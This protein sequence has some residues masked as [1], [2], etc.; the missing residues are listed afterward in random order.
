MAFDPLSW[1][2]SFSLGGAVK[3]A[4]KKLRPDEFTRALRAAV[5]AW[6]AELPPEWVHIE[7][8]FAIANS[9]EEATGDRAKLAK[10]LH[11]ERIPSVQVWLAALLEQWREARAA[12]D[13]SPWPFFQLSEADV[14]PHL[15]RLAVELHAAGGV[16]LKRLG[17]ELLRRTQ[18]QD[19]AESQQ[20]AQHL[21]DAHIAPPSPDDSSVDEINAA[22]QQLRAGHLTEARDA[23]EELRRSRWASLGPV[24]KYRVLANLGI[25]A[26]R[27]GDERQAARLFFE[28]FDFNPN[29]EKA[30]LFQAWAIQL[31]GDR[32]RSHELASALRQEFPSMPGAAALWVR[33][34]PPDTE[35]AFI[36]S[37]LPEHLHEDA[38]VACAIAQHA[39]ALEDWESAEHVLRSAASAGED[40]PDLLQLL[41]EVLLSQCSEQVSEAGIEAAEADALRESISLFGTAE[42][43]LSPDENPRRLASL[44]LN[45]AMAHIALGDDEAARRQIDEVWS[46]NLT[47][48]DLRLRRVQLS[49]GIVPAQRL[50]TELDSV[51]NAE[52]VPPHFPLVYALALRRRKRDG[53]ADQA[54]DRLRELF[55]PAIQ[56]HLR[57]DAAA[58]A[59]QLLIDAERLSDAEGFLLELDVTLFPF[60]PPLLRA[61]LA[62]KRN[63]I[64]EARRLADDSVAALDDAVTPSWRVRLAQLLLDVDAPEPA[65]DIL[66]QRVTNS[67]LSSAEA[68]LI[69]AAE[70]AGHHQFL[71]AYCRQLR[72]AGVASAWLLDREITAL[73][74]AGDF[75]RAIDAAS[76][77][78]ADHPDDKLVR[79]QRSRLALRIGR[80]DFVDSEPKHLVDVDDATPTVGVATV[81]VLRAKAEH[82]RARAFAYEL[83]RRHRTA[84]EAHQAFLMAMAAPFGPEATD[85]M[86]ISRVQAGTAVCLQ[87]DDEETW[88]IIEDGPDASID[89]DE[90]AP[91]HPLAVSLLDKETGDV[92]DIGR[93]RVRQRQATIKK[94]LSKHVFRYHDVLNNW[95]RRFPD[96]PLVEMFRA[97]SDTDELQALLS[98]SLESSQRRIER[99]ERLY[100][101]NVNVSL[102]MFCEGLTTTIVGGIGHLASRPLCPIK[103]AYVAG[104]EFALFEAAASNA[105]KVIAAPSALA[106]ALIAGFKPWALGFDLLL[107]PSSLDQLRRHVVEIREHAKA[108]GHLTTEG[109]RVVLIE[110]DR[111]A[112][113]ASADRLRSFIADLEVETTS[114]DEVDCTCFDERDW[115]VLVQAIGIG[116]AE[117]VAH[118]VAA[119]ATL[120]T[121]D[122][123]SGGFAFKKGANRIWSQLALE[124]GHARGLVTTGTNADVA[125]QLLGMGYQPTRPT[126]LSFLAAS[127]RARW[128]PDSWPLAQHLDLFASRGDTNEVARY[129]AVVLKNIWR[130]APD[131]SPAQAITIRILERLAT[132]QGS[133]RIITDL[134]DLIDTTFGLDVLN[135][136]RAKASIRGWLAARRLYE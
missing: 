108:D 88:L 8:M 56:R 92:V 61:E 26:I 136:D 128:A 24:E 118:A 34:I 19:E 6:H 48:T 15:R 49:L 14:R 16:D 69:A 93:G 50:V 94:I 31:R 125:A 110:R 78:L 40:S 18:I 57:E 104:H 80:T 37:S 129:A 127:R 43:Q 116:E 9:S 7:T 123:V 17:P 68:T 135:A 90:Y 82:Q 25:V 71:K 105:T 107:T 52:D 74:A 76:S 134:L 75:S 100:A 10:E 67:R 59:A 85:D 28:A 12:Q 66:K 1:A 33:T 3:H 64:E 63:D 124:E 36:L 121:D 130:H 72:D 103:C 46:L 83:Y 79:L 111:A 60:L 4:W 106:T 20:P 53:D 84:P 42:Q 117:C 120:W 113:E 39:V 115:Q 95:E 32:P 11:A 99:L 29:D 70:A 54:V 122:A 44:R 51:A 5:A 81:E 126:A 23:L 101:E 96:K 55:D 35:P 91:K 131:T 87:E 86:S 65:F 109:G 62:L 13:D 27:L 58:I 41:G 102:H 89:H 47:D 22:V 97:P 73:A 114:V 2:L 112:L 119:K 45:L 38:D 98:P 77:F 133:G 30:R 21:D 132:R